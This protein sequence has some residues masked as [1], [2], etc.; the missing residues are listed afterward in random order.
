VAEFVAGKSLYENCGP[1]VIVS[2]EDLK[3]LEEA[4]PKMRELLG[5][6]SRAKTVREMGLLLEQLQLGLDSC[7]KEVA[8][9]EFELEDL[10]VAPPEGYYHACVARVFFSPAWGEY[11][12]PIELDT[13][14]CYVAVL[15]VPELRPFAD[16]ARC[17]PDAGIEEIDGAI[18]ALRDAGHTVERDD[19][20]LAHVFGRLMEDEYLRGLE[21]DRDRSAGA[22]S[23]HSHQ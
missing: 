3:H 9:D 21:P 15:N 22:A 7:W 11:V 19:A 20:R 10:D 1:Y 23:D 14:I 18:L 4:A 17:D 2:E 13:S 8:S 16:F 5:K 12:S 6:A